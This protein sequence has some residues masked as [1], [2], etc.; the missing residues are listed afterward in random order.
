MITPLTIVTFHYVR[1]LARSRYPAIKGLETEG[2]RGQLDYMQRHYRVVG[3]D[4]VLAAAAG[5][6][7]LPDCA[8]WL[9]FDDGLA[10]HYET[11]FPLLR[12]RGLSGAF[13]P[14][15]RPL[16]EKI[17]LDVHKI[18]FILAA[19]PDI[20][21]LRQRLLTMMAENRT[22]YDLAPDQ[23]YVSRYE[24]PGRYDPAPVVF[25]KRMLQ[26][27]L[28]EQL[29][30]KMVDALF[31]EFVTRDETAFAE[32][33]YLTPGNLREMRAAGMGVGGHGD[34]HCW[35]DTLAEE[36]LAAEVDR[37]VA[38]LTGLGVP[39]DRW[40]MCYPHGGYNDRAKALVKARGG[41]VGL[42][43]EGGLADLGA[44]D[45]L[46]LPRLDTNDLPKTADAP[47]ADWT[48]RARGKGAA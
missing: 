39:K 16:T 8:A 17:V 41:V 21:R 24:K 19:S 40:I 26:K 47:V 25:V 45:P 30:P 18:H 44:G 5:E 15:V 20:G 14:P 22:E 23:D 9:T 48:V 37:T 13:F 6:A 1:D 7:D 38:F 10:D 27:G 43:V 33:L 34:S 46:A 32:E 3:T 2:F 35:L 4:A 36:D 12:E 28:P 42:T 31:T 11:V 29:R